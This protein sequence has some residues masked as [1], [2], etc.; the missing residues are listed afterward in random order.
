MPPSNGL[1]NKLNKWQCLIG[2]KIPGTQSG[3]TAFAAH[4]RGTMRGGN[5]IIR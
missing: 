2:K 4:G 1:S 3:V 5:W